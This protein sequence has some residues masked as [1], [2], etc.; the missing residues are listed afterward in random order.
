M[1]E[2]LVEAFAE[3]SVERIVI[4]LALGVL[5]GVWW[6]ALERVGDDE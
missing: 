3:L 4:A 2:Q 6:A 1:M 5:L